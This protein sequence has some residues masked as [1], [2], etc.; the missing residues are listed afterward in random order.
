MSVTQVLKSVGHRRVHY[1]WVIVA[2]AFGLQTVSTAMRMAFGT[3]VEPLTETFGWSRGSIGLAYALQFVVSAV[4]APVAG[5]L[6][7]VYGV[8]RTIF[9]GAALFALGMVLTG[10]IT[11]LW[12][13]YFYYS[14][15]VGVALA[16][17]SVPLITA[18]TYWF[19]RRQGLAIGLVMASFGVGPVVAAPVIVSLIGSMGWGTAIM[20]AGGVSGLLILG[21]SVLF[22]GRPADK[23]MR[24]YG[25]SADEPVAPR[26]DRQREKARAAAF[27][28]RAR[29]TF[30]FWNMANIHF[31][32]C[33]GH[34]IIIVY[35]A[36]IAIHRGLPPVAAAG[37]VSTFAAVSVFTRFLTPALSD[38]FSPK[39]TMAVSHFLQG[40]TVLLL[41]VAQEPWQFYA[42]AVAFGIGYG[43]EGAVFPLLNSRYYRNAPL[44][45]AFGWQMFGASLGMALGG[46][47]GGYLFDV[48]GSY[49]ATIIVSMA[50]SLGGMASILLLASPDRHL[51]PDWEQRLKAKAQAVAR[52][53]AGTIPH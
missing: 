14:G 16:I 9:V 5:W 41:L 40:I 11:E 45:T 50:A 2:A 8:R 30:N 36:S 18:V 7:E 19:R 28:R 17:F 6:G 51:I 12:Q 39:G 43:G 15:M 26:P 31:L 47:I 35:A 4:F 38:R 44:G 29:G 32:G 25:A 27:F 49:T 34:S 42:F 52:A 46:W 21:V 23:G 48:T 53:D 37:V 3:F 20:L 13:F 24:P 22:Y 10:T 1:A 33:V